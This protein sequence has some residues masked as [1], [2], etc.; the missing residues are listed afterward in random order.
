MIIRDIPGDYTVDAPRPGRI[1]KIEYDNG[2]EKKY[3]L[4]YLPYSYDEKEKYDILYLIH[5]GGGRQEDYFGDME[6]STRF[7]KSIDKLSVWKELMT[8]IIVSA[9]VY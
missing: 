3:A 4:V 5:G 7:K 2:R 8:I 1:T 9:T 6:Y